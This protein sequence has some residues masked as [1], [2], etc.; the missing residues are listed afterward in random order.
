MLAAAG[1][2]PA[3]GKEVSIY[4][5]GAGTGTVFRISRFSTAVQAIIHGSNYWILPSCLYRLITQ[6]HLGR[7]VYGTRTRKVLSR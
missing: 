2:G 5:V 4:A 7:I 1:N 3:A 6:R